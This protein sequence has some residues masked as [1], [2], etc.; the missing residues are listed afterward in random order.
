MKV[1]ARRFPLINALRAL[2]ALSVLA[3]HA[4]GLF[5]GGLRDDAAIRP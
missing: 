4:L 5:G 2:A 3:F 1:Q